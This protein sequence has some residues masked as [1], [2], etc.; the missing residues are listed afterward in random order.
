MIIVK[1]KFSLELAMK[2][3]KGRRPIA[4]L[5]F[6]LTWAPDGGGWT[7]PRPGRFKA[8]KDPVPIVQEVGSA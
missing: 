1:V 8:G 7:K 2:A 6:F 4:L 3:Q 5:F